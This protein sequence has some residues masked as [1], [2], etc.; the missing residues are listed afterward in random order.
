M[1]S[2][3]DWFFI[4][5]FLMMKEILTEIHLTISTEILGLNFK[6][7]L[8]KPKMLYWK[9]DYIFCFTTELLKTKPKTSL[10]CTMGK[11]ISVSAM[12]CDFLPLCS[13]SIAHVQVKN[14]SQGLRNWVW[15]LHVA[16]S[17]KKWYTQILIIRS[18]APNGQ[19]DQVLLYQLGLH[20]LLLFN[21]FLPELYTI[22]AIAK[23]CRIVG[24]FWPNEMSQESYT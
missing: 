11:D 15:K 3:W 22:K 20:F 19:I 17:S 2:G 12:L 16:M 18:S 7:H 24:E 23:L 1:H 5:P 9:N 13:V 21:C 4:A 10:Q 14:S 8:L 6:G